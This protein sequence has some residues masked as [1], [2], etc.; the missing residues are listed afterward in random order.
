MDPVAG[1]WPLDLVIGSWFMADC[2]WV[3]QQPE[4]RSQRPKKMTPESMIE[5]E[6]PDGFKII[7]DHIWINFLS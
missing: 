2:L 4:A 6:E 7:S 1:C 5:R 3:Y